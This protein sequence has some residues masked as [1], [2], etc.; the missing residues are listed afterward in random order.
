MKLI[1]GDPT[2]KKYLTGANVDTAEFIVVTS[3]F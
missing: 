3:G 1:Q 2:D